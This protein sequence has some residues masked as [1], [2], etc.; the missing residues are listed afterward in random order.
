MN[1]VFVYG[2]LKVGGRFAERFD[3]SRMNVE[4]CSINGTMY[5]TKSGYPMILIGTGD[6]ITG[7]L[8]TYDDFAGVLDVMDM[9]EGYPT[10][11][12][13]SVINVDGEEVFVYHGINEQVASMEKVESGTWILDK[14]PA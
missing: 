7:E 12:S 6:V 9:I 8:H 13:R 1:K 14:C 5:D 2:T 11:Y 4:E 3:N 10:Y